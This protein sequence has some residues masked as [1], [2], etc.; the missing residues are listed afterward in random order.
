MAKKSYALVGTWDFKGD[1][2]GI[3]VFDYDPENGT[4]TQNGYYDPE[5]SA[6][7]QCYDPVRQIVYFVD[8]C[9]GHSNELPGGGY[10]RAYR[11]TEA[12]KLEFINEQCIY[13]GKPAGI[14]L[15]RS[16]EYILA[17]AHGGRNAVTKV[18]YHP[19][20]S[21]GSC[22]QYEDVG[23]AL[24]RVQKDGSLGEV[25]DIVLHQGITPLKSQ[26]HA[27]LHSI[28]G[29][30]DGEIFYACDKGLDKI[31][32]YRLDRKQGKLLRMAEKQMDYA[33]APRYG[34]FHPVLPVFY[35]NN[36]TDRRLFA[37]QYDRLSGQLTTLA[38]VVL[39]DEEQASPADI[40]VDHKGRYLYASLRRADKIVVFALDERGIP[41]KIQDFPSGGSVRGM[42]LS[43]DGK[44]MLGACNETGEVRVYSVD[45]DGMLTDTGHS[46]PA[47]HAANVA[48]VEVPNQ[49]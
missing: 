26:V 45:E 41:R 38:E 47:A 43:P 49:P 2:K 15:D 25:C 32:S 22:V 42:T 29:S 3:Y 14:C 10:V 36:E 20:G 44:F 4:L 12:G 30:P 46:V 8:E 6:G 7:Q 27:H 18:I 1:K 31:Y 21:F 16:G 17:A 19:D 35:E 24:L 39:S 28:C 40:T 13:M 5:V 33:T 34:A 48:V 9:E 37:F 23:M 11:L